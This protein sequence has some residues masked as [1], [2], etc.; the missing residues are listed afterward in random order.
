MS[1]YKPLK[2]GEATQIQMMFG[3]WNILDDSETSLRERLK[4]SKQWANFRMMHALIPK[5]VN[6][7]MDTI[8]LEL[9][10]SGYTAGHRRSLLSGE[11]LSFHC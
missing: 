3:V 9:F 5:V 11:K 7:M 1:E 2:P 8:P 10:Q 6:S 4:L